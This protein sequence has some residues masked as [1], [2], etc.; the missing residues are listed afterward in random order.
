MEGEAGFYFVGLHF[1]YAMSSTM[2]HGVGRGVWK[3][4]QAAGVIQVQVRER[5]VTHIAGLEPE[6]LHL[7]E[8]GIFEPEP[9][10]R[11]G[12]EEPPELGRVRDVTGA[13]S[14]LDEDQALVAL[15]QQ[16]MAAHAPAVEEPAL[17]VDEAS[18]DGAHRTAIEMVNYEAHGSLPLTRALRVPFGRGVRHGPHGR[19]DGPGTELERSIAIPFV[20]QADGCIAHPARRGGFPA[21]TISQVRSMADPTTA[22]EPP[23]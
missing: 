14:G 19:Y 4:R 23:R 17:S 15:D 6:A 11:G 16:A 12:S 10:L 1:L 3:V 9:R 22:A 5:D 20:L 13:K 8:R 2:I 21:E 18:S 7:V